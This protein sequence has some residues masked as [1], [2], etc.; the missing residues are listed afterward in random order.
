MKAS[1]IPLH[2]HTHTHTHIHTQTH[3]HRGIHTQEHTYRNTFRSTIFI[4][5]ERIGLLRVIW[6]VK[7]LELKISLLLYLLYKFV[8]QASDRSF[9][10]KKMKSL[11]IMVNAPEP[12]FSIP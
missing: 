5:T 7:L 1:S 10:N 9:P 4:F 6:K 12:D 11:N 8:T 2:T 3:T